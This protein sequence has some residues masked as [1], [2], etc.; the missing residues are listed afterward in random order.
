MKRHSVFVVIVHSWTD[1]G[2]VNR[3]HLGSVVIH[4]VHFL[5]VG[6]NYELVAPTPTTTASVGVADNSS[7]GGFHLSKILQA[8]TTV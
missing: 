6:N 4:Q 2:A 5:S 7:L 3:D 1:L 8:F